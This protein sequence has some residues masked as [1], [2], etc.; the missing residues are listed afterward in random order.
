LKAEQQTSKGGAV[1]III[2]ARGRPIDLP[3]DD[4]KGGWIWVEAT[5]S[6]NPLGWTPP[7]FSDGMWTAWTHSGNTYNRQQP[8]LESGETDTSTDGFSSWDIIIIIVAIL[9]FLLKR[10]F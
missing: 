10:R 3:E 9:F 7:D 6:S 5:G 1:G 4:A 8:V 2:D